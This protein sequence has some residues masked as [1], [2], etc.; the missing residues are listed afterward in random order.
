MRFL[1]AASFAKTGGRGR[2][3]S[4]QGASLRFLV[5]VSS[6]S[7]FCSCI[8]SQGTTSATTSLFSNPRLPAIASSVLYSLCRDVVDQRQV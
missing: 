3:A 2:V 4:Q 1:V 5:S 8:V 6:P 7:L